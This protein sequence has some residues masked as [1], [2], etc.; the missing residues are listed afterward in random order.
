MTIFIEQASRGLNCLPSLIIHN[1]THLVNY[2]NQ[3]LY[4]KIM[5]I[6]RCHRKVPKNVHKRRITYFYS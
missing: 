6:A 4:V 2:P 5:S 3:Q 1:Q